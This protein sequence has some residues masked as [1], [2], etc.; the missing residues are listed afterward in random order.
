MVH[1]ALIKL[2]R[3]LCE[4]MSALLWSIRTFC[5]LCPLGS[6]VVLCVRVQDA[7]WE[8]EKAQKVRLLLD[9]YQLAAWLAGFSA[10]SGERQ[11]H[12]NTSGSCSS[13]QKLSP[14]IP[15]QISLF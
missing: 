6:P 3:S 12:R 13:V 15:Q 7:P 14:A 11:E 4:V 8:I 2:R 10:A 1:E 9:E 5:Y